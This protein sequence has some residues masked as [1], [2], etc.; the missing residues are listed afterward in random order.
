ME[1][2]I[3]YGENRK[4]YLDKYLISYNESEICEN[5]YPKVIHKIILLNYL[6]KD[7]ID[8]PIN[9][10]IIINIDILPNN[11]YDLLPY[12]QL[13]YCPKSFIYEKNWLYFNFLSISR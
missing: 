1:Y 5:L 13:Y 4:T 10:P 6:P 11:I 8:Y 12:V 9:L 3:Y 7:L 2:H